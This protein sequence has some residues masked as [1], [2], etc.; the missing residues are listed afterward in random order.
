M[1][2]VKD[3]LFQKNVSYDA[4]K[5]SWAV[6]VKN[7]D[8]NFIHY[9]KKKPVWLETIDKMND[10][11]LKNPDP[12]GLRNVHDNIDKIS[13]KSFNKYTHSFSDSSVE[14]YLVTLTMKRLLCDVRY[15]FKLKHKNEELSCLNGGAMPS[16]QCG[17]LW[18][19]SGI[20]NLLDHRIQDL[21]LPKQKELASPSHSPKKSHVECTL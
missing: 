6:V 2:L 12:I 10:V 13:L 19:L 3:A 17:T 18:R 7:G 16:S 11:L 5:N 9:F 4:K 15:I 21:D 1:I 8:K 14:N 20:V